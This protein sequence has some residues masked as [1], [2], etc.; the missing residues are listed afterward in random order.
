M[1][2]LL[3][4]VEVGLDLANAYQQTRKPKKQRIAAD[5]ILLLLAGL[6]GVTAVGFGLAAAYL[7]IACVLSKAVAAL[8]TGVIALGMGLI[9]LLVSRLIMRPAKN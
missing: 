1:K 5:M 3:A 2:R 9:A 6:L 8:L 7:G 4:A